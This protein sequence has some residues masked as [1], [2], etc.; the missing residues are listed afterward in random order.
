MISAE[1]LGLGEVFT[2]MT[3]EGSTGECVGVNHERKEGKGFP[4]Q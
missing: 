3:F 1:R 4:G 2:K